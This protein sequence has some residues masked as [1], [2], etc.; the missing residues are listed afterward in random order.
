[1]TW[2]F[3]RTAN[4]RS[5][6]ILLIAI[7]IKYTKNRDLKKKKVSTNDIFHSFIHSSIHSTQIA[8]II[9]DQENNWWNSQQYKNEDEDSNANKEK[10]EQLGST[11][12]SWWI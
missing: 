1:M 2:I 10:C 9:P 12:A 4:F 7:S 5:I 6:C 8:T 3:K 11:V